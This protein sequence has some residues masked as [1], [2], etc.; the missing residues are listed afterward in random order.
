[1]ELILFLF[2]EI[3]CLIS[4]MALFINDQLNMTNMLRNVKKMH[5]FTGQQCMK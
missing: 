2:R 3:A 1:M 5:F 4:L